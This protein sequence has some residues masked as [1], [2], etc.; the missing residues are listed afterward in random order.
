MYIQYM[1][2]LLKKYQKKT[3]VAFVVAF[4]KP[5]ERSFHM[6]TKRILAI[7][8]SVMMIFSI[9]PTMAFAEESGFNNF[10]AVNTYT[11]GQFTDVKADDWFSANVA[12]VFTDGLMVGRGENYFA[13]NENMTVAEA[14]TIAARLNAIYLTGEENF[15]PSEPWYKVYTD[16]CKEKGI[17]DSGNYDLNALV[18]RGQFAE[19]FAKALPE[20]AFAKINDIVNGA[21][22][23]VKEGDKFGAAIYFLYRAGILVGNDAKGT[24]ASNS[25]IMRME[26]AAITDR[27][28][29]PAHRQSLSLKPELGDNKY[30]VTFDYGDAKFKNEQVIVS[31][32]EKVA[33]PEKPAKSG[34]TFA[35]W[36]T[37]KWGGV[38]FD[39]NS[40]IVADTTIYAHWNKASGG[41][42]GSYNTIKT[43]ADVL[44]TVSDI[45]LSTEWDNPPSNSW[46]TE[47]GFSCYK[48]Q[49]D[50]P[51]IGKT[52]SIAF[53]YF[54]GKD[55]NCF[56]ADVRYSVKKS[57]SN[58]V[59]E[60][61]GLKITF[62]MKN[63][64]LESITPSGLT[65]D[66]AIFNDKTFT[67]PT[68]ST[69]TT[70][71]DI[72]PSD[73]PAEIID[74]DKYWKND[75]ESPSSCFKTDDSVAFST[76][77]NYSDR[78]SLTA[79]LTKDGDNWKITANWGSN[80]TFVMVEGALT[81]IVISDA[82]GN[83]ADLN[84]TYAP[85]VTKTGTEI[86]ATNKD[87][88]IAPDDMIPEGSWVS[89]NGAKAFINPDGMLC[90]DNLSANLQVNTT[91]KFTKTGDN[92][93]FENSDATFTL[94][95]K[96]EKLDS[97]EVSGATGEYADLN[98]KYAPA[99][100][101]DPVITLSTEGDGSGHFED[102]W[103]ITLTSIEVPSGSTL[104][105]QTSGHDP[106][107]WFWVDNGEYVEIYKF[108]ADEGSEFTGWNPNYTEES[109][110]TVTANFTLK[111]N[112]EIQN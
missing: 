101:K 21:I 5:K 75:A 69:K 26:V 90:F 38:K 1:V 61:G 48:L 12:S 27:V 100:E 9:I 64:V 110:F 19:I 96:D 7:L 36:Y 51:E 99:P 23:D 76:S 54:D 108:V 11:D 41:G 60:M 97:I 83:F 66:S 32:G 49:D 4:E 29:V 8:L 89:A 55:P 82:T 72:L 10:K 18:T 62:N 14:M 57:G 111:A 47:D 102:I 50:I 53:F 3:K 43:I 17:A 79:E 42:G 93:V 73:F 34:S 13:P 37:E 16:Y 88:P 59:W 52:E 45:P 2:F 74:S 70:V 6:K 112:V 35:G 109:P 30:T 107:N 56:S 71:A 77:N 84:G 58:Y 24:Y 46:S 28:A 65:N 31:G 80:V 67:A 39:F 15:T 81:S 68:G 87:F 63:G 95:M 20:E 103:E 78:I 94:N 44:A 22:P 104:Y 92:Y 106:I 85:V 86:F 105:T 98:G 91:E 25:N 40:Q 33:E